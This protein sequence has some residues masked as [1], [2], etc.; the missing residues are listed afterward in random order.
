MVIFKAVLWTGKP[1][2]PSPFQNLLLP[3]GIERAASTS[4]ISRCSPVPGICGEAAS[5]QVWLVHD[6]G[7]QPQDPSF[8]SLLRVA[9][10]LGHRLKCSQV[11]PHHIQGCVRHSITSVAAQT[12][13]GNCFCV[14]VSVRERVCVCVCVCVCVHASGTASPVWQLRRHRVIA[15]V[16]M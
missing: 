15:S 1:S 8:L 11:R 7:T 10:F 13:S 5:L 12:S 16:C 6:L 2:L 4:S 9:L 3:V 14:Y